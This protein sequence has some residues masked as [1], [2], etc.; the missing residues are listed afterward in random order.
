MR[1]PNLASIWALP[2]SVLLLLTGCTTAG[3]TAQL[4]G[5]ELDPD[6]QAEWQNLHSQFPDV[7]QPH[8]EIIRRVDREVWAATI[9]DCLR[10]AGYPDVNADPDG[11][12]SF[13]TL[14][15][16]A[17]QFA[18]AKYVCVAQF[19]LETRFTAPLTEEQLGRLYDYMTLV[20]AP[21]LEAQ[22][23]DIPAPPSKQRFVETY[24]TAPEWLP[25]ANLPLDVLQ[26]DRLAEIQDLCPEDPQKDSQYYLY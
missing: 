26:S 15:S 9:A 11:G 12:L 10:E 7:V 2:L 19:P 16:Q 8:V 13:E 3:P 21:C 25:Y 14:E 1:L 4:A 23:F 5:G 17:E 20:Q 24:A 22:G 18:L 6:V